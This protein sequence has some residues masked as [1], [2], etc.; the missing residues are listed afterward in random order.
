M[1]EEMYTKI[2]NNREITL[3]KLREILIN[4]QMNPLRRNTTSWANV[5]LFLKSL[6][7]EKFKKIYAF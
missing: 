4:N 6:P 2:K 7:S 1:F 5:E 3:E